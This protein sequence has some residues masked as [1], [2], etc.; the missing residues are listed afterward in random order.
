MP[1]VIAE[2]DVSQ[3]DDQTGVLYHFPKRYKSLL[4]PG[5][6]V[7]YYKGKLR[8]KSFAASRR[9]P[10]PHYFAVARIGEISSASNSSKGDLYAQIEDFTRFAEAVPIKVNGTY[11]ETIP[12][13]RVN[14]HWRDGVRPLSQADY[15]AILAH[16]Q[17]VPQQDG[18]HLADSD[19]GT[20]EF[21]SAYEGSKRSYLGTRYE[22]RPELRKRAVEIHGLSCNVCGFNFEQ[23]YGDYA[24]GLI[25]VHHV[26]PIS[27]GE[28]ERVVDPKKDL[29]TLCA[30]C[31]AVVHRK[32]ETTLTVEQLKSMVRGKWSS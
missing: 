31:H 25:H 13:S 32:R 27:D 2:N 3:W 29:I 11:L 8:D 19:G 28:G 24:K 1:V 7:V 26:V 12:A 5:M 15:E 6:Q 23:V 16:T 30:N 20:F 14:N 21:E 10:D 17:L 9:S 4:T 18:K 22:R